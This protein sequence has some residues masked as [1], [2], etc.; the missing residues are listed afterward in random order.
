MYLG[1][2][3]LNLSAGYSHNIFRIS[4][5]VLAI[6]RIV[7]I[8]GL[9]VFTPPLSAQN[10]EPAG[11]N[12]ATDAAPPTAAELRAAEL[13]AAEL[14]AA[15][16]ALTAGEAGSGVPAASQETVSVFVILRTILVLILVA[17][18]IYGIVYIFKKMAR[19]VEQQESHLRV[20]ATASLGQNRFAHVVSVGTRAWLIGAGDGGVNLIAELEEQEAVDAMLLDASRRNAETAPGRFLDFKAMLRRLGAGN[21]QPV[22]DNGIRPDKIRERRERLKGL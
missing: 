10:Q 17:A 14:E 18:A 5:A 3:K 15:E 4:A 6:L 21:S 20:L 19:P 22:A 2:E 7:L 12:S 8:A 16:L 1:G 13:R 11:E 9:F